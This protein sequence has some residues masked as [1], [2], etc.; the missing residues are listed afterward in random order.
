MQWLAWHRGPHVALIRGSTTVHLSKPHLGYDSTAEAPSFPRRTHTSL[1]L[2]WLTLKLISP[3][4][5]QYVPSPATNAVDTCYTGPPSPLTSRDWWRCVE[6]LACAKDWPSRHPDRKCVRWLHRVNGP[7]LFHASARDGHTA[8]QES[9]PLYPGTTPPHSYLH[10]SQLFH[11]PHAPLWSRVRLPHL[12]VAWSSATSI[13]FTTL[14]IP[15]TESSP[16]R[17]FPSFCTPS[18]VTRP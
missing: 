16:W 8:R 14:V 15:D 3:L 5:V 1:H 10:N 18:C 6:W 11:F 9:F 2:S 13:A 4:D 12:Q 7:C 17:S